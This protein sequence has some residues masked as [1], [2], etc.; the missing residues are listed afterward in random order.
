MCAKG[1]DIHMC[2]KPEDKTKNHKSNITSNKNQG[3][4]KLSESKVN[5]K[6]EI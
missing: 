3:Q 4:I 6:I 5:N 1:T 2:V